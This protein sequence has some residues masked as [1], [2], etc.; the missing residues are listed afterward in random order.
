LNWLATWFKTVLVAFWELG[1]EFTH[2]R[3]TE[4]KRDL[5]KSTSDR[6]QLFTLEMDVSH[7]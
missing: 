4:G 3:D 7:E 1:V 2:C 6:R 5:N